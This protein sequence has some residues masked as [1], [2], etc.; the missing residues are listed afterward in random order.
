MAIN[1]LQERKKQK[2]LLLL[3]ALVI[4]LTLLVIWWGF[5]RKE[6]PVVPSSQFFTF[7]QLRI[8]WSLLESLQLEKLQPFEEIK[9]FEKE[10]GRKNPFLPY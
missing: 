2:Y 1:F 10:I 7:P 6:A 3:S 4:A 5:F 8:N 9:P